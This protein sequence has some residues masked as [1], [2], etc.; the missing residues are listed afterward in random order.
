MSHPPLR[1][2]AV[3]LGAAAVAAAGALPLPARAA[4]YPVINLKTDCGAKGDGV[5]ND[6][7]ALQRAVEKI[8]AAGGG[9]L[10]IPAGVYKIGGQNQGRVA[11]QPYYRYWTML[12]F[13]NL[14]FL[15]IRGSAGAV[16][17]LAA[18]LHYGSF[19]PD[20]GTAQA[21]P[22]GEDYN[23]LYRARVGAMIQVEDSSDVTIENLELDGRNG[24]L[25]L[26]G[27]WGDTGIQ[28][29]ATGMRLL[30]NTNVTISDVHT[31]HHGL[32]GLTI[33]YGG[34]TTADPP[35][36]HTVTGVR[37]EYNGRQGLSWTGGNSLTVTDS[38]FNHTGR[39]AVR[40][41]PTSGLDI[42]A[43]S[44]V[45]RNGLFTRCEFVDNGGPG[46]IATNGDGGYTR[47]EGCTFWGTTTWSAYTNKP[48]LVF[49]W[50]N[51]YGRNNLG[52]GGADAALAT[53]YADCLFEDRPW[54]NGQV[55][56]DGYLVTDEASAD[57]G[58]NVQ[59]ADCRFVARQVRSVWTNTDTKV[60]TFLR[61]TFDHRY[62]GVA[63]GGIQSHPWG[64]RF[65]A[66][67]FTESTGTT[68]SRW[69]VHLNGVVVDPS[70]DGTP[71]TVAG[72]TVR[73]GSPTGAVG[74]IP[75]GTYG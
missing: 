7:G 33:G 20:D 55:Y 14:A 8:T 35:K 27:R 28:A 4:A 17:R 10:D 21:P 36:P 1:R 29:T 49:K 53:K 58:Q 71:T 13:K 66:C 59:F 44:S 47:F 48:G 70:P 72:P 2:R 52:Y 15:H 75:V 54:T 56:R 18:G 67:A 12:E 73:W 69:Y 19:N 16:L 24:T 46:V 74:V 64:A 3:L 60:K 65:V 63:E 61:C 38:Q 41:A 68:T 6:T 31:H 25:V 45:C 51:F 11:G 26:G 22:A 30:R 23:E 5:G 42:E 34:L 9:T 39:G 43:E 37:S 62:A 32:D 57:S 50:S 40:S